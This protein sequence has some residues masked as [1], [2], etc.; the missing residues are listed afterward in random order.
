MTTGMPRRSA[1]IMLLLC[2]IIVGLS[3]WAAYSMPDPVRGASIIGAIYG[4]AVGIF[5]GAY[6]LFALVTGRG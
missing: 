3:F 5:V 4:A 1:A 2:L 6:A